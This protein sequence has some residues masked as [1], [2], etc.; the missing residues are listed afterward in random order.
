MH[1]AA[2]EQL[3]PLIASAAASGERAAVLDVG[4]GSGYLAAAF[5][6]MG[7]R[8][9][10][11]DRLETLVARARRNLAADKESQVE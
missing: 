3:E 1:A 6:R 8:V 7:A 9:V 10:G 5:A 4:V 2:L 11:I